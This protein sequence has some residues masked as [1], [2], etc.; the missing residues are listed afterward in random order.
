[1]RVGYGWAGSG[2]RMIECR[3]GL[4]AVRV[5]RGL[6]VEREREFRVLR[7]KEIEKK[8]INQR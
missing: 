3:R 5:V 8:K 6:K 1:M 7:R 2:E 4:T